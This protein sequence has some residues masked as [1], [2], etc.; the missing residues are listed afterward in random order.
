VIAFIKGKLVQS[1]PMSVVLEAGGLGYKVFIPPSVFTKLPPLQEEV[2]LHTSFV[3][4]ELSHT[5]Y[6]FLTLEDRSLFEALMDVTGVGPKTALNL[7]GNLTPYELS[8]AITNHDIATISKVPGIGKK[9]AERLIMEMRDKISSLLPHDPSD[10]A[11]KSSDPH[12]QK[13]SDAMS[14][15]INLGYNQMTAEKAIKKTLK[16]ISEPI[17]LSDLITVALKNM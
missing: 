8:I 12:L 11:V 7:I 5:L 15:L 14:T 10:Y 17:N 3:V 9:T 4:R 6:G 1:G 13:I 16:D 2:I